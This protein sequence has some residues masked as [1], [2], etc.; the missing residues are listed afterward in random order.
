MGPKSFSAATCLLPAPIIST[1]FPLPITSSQEKFEDLRSK[2]C[3]LSGPQCVLS[4]AKEN[5][6]PPKQGFT[7]CLAMDGIKV[8]ATGF[9]MRM[10]RY[11]FVL[12]LPTAGGNFGPMA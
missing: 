9:D 5:R 3:N 10:K 12:N 1:S 11:A 2:G 6:A 8:V 4:C 7:C